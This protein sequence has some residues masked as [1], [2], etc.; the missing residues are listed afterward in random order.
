M[1]P[2]GMFSGQHSRDRWP[3]L[4]HLGGHCLTL[5]APLPPATWFP[6]SQA[7]PLA[8]NTPTKMGELPAPKMPSH[9][10]QPSP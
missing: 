1:K 7:D 8:P 5:Q 6:S 4:G 9:Q 3:C 10:S 2:L